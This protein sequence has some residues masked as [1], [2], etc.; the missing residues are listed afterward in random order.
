MPLANTT[1]CV[2]TPTGRGA[3]ATI[4]VCGQLKALRQKA[5]EAE[6]PFFIAKNGTPAEKQTL[7]RIVFGSWGDEDLVICRTA[8]ECLEIHSHGGKLAVARIVESL[9]EAGAERICWESA[10]NLHSETWL[11]DYHVALSRCTTERTAEFLLQ[12]MHLG[13][14]FWDRLQQ[15]T[16]SI[17]EISSARKWT[18]F[19]Q[20][21]ET[22]WE[23]VIGGP[24]NVGKSSLINRMLGY[25]R[26][27]VFDQP[28]TTR[29]VVSA[30]TAIDGWPV[31]FS[32]TA[33]QR[34]TSDA[35][36][37]QGIT[38]AI[39]KLQQADLQILVFDQSQE[40]DEFTLSLSAEF[41]EAILIFHKSDLP[42]N[43]SWEQIEFPTSPLP[44]SSKTGEGIEAVISKISDKLVP[45]LP[46]AGAVYP[47]SES[48]RKLL[49]KQM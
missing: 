16:A 20:H 24:A 32:D 9:V 30:D 23:V 17:N 46:P 21:L 4:R 49:E 37:T 43:S 15:R 31:R 25:E 36:E 7:D 38:Y 6:V 19:G 3:V 10:F 41:P 35:L 2:L 18:L 12:Q 29:D 14:S 40:T 44:V 13:G 1:V 8:Q 45:V 39:A 5:E 11:A 48:Q 42:M 26:A 47:V 28:G 33:G 27:I 22:P 34:Q